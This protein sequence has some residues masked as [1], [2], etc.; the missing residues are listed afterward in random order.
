[1]LLLAHWTRKMFQ[2]SW[3]N[4]NNGYVEGVVRGYFDSLLSNSSY[5][6]LTQCDTLES[7][8]DQCSSSF[9]D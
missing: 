5:Y 3:F 4:A 1:M 7:K 8:C 2:S 6:S 9:W